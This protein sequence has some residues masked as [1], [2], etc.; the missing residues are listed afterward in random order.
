MTIILNS[1]KGFLKIKMITIINFKTYKQ[2][3]GVLRLAKIIEKNLKKGQVIIGVQ[4][5]DIGELAKKIKLKIY[6]QHVDWQKP[7]RNTGFIIPESVKEDGADGAFLNHSEHKLAFEVLKKTIKRCKQLRLKT[8][9]F[10]TDFKEAKKIDRLKPDFIIFEP[11]ELVAGKISVSE[12]KPSIIKKIAKNIKT[13]FLVGAG[14]H[15]N[16]DVKTALSLGAKGVA[17]SSAV[18]TSKNPGKKLKEL[19][20]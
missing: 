20:S 3:K 10:A 1:G 14:I 19:F 11:R 9:I 2:G 18:T 4:A 6:A 7:G 12:S 16:K 13:S 17:V 15:T 5:T 8:A